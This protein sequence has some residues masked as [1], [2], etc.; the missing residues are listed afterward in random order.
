MRREAMRSRGLLSE[1]ESF[2]QYCKRL[3]YQGW[4]LG[5]YFP[6]LYE[7]HMD[8]P[9]SAHSLIRS[10]ADLTNGRPL[11]ADGFD[12]LTVEQRVRQIRA[13]AVRCQMASVDPRR[14]VGWRSALLQLR[15]RLRGRP[16]W[17][18]QETA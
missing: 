4:L 10:D 7:D 17:W 9:R 3:A 2:P 14:Y 15:W 8:D 5:W 13:F 16:A 1:R 6:F 11:T 18:K 12:V